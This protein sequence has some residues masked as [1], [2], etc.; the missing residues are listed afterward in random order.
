MM[1]FSIIGMSEG[2]G[3]PYS[4]SAICNGYNRALMENCGFPVIPRYLEKENYPGDFISDRVNV[5]SIWTQDKKLSKKIAD[6]C[7][8]DN[9][10]SNIEAASAGVDGILYARDDAENHIKMLE[11][12]IG[13]GIPIYIDKPIALRVKD[14]A[15]ILQL[16]CNET[17]LF[18][19]S[20]LS[21]S[22]SWEMCKPFFHELH[23][24]F[25]I[26][27]ESPKS[28][29]KYSIHIIEPVLNLLPNDLKV[30]N[31]KKHVDLTGATSVSVKYSRD[32]NL[33]FSTTGKQFGH[34]KFFIKTK[35]HQ[36]EIT[37]DDIFFCFKNAM[38]KFHDGV[39]NKTKMVNFEKVKTVVKIIEA[40]LTK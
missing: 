40:G 35:N 36:I 31:M 14:L 22:K 37:P 6:T 27:A 34:I 15:K 16:A 19:C 12:L 17:Q 2:N 30:L 21:Y 13:S 20:A 39:K 28:W 9:V 1:K 32:I 18:T 24:N 29:E 3:H 38:L 10:L 11:P 4:W 5:C 26:Y 23:E 7:F 33:K 8:I 25:I